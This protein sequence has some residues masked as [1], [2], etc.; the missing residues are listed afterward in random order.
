MP[1]LRIHLNRHAVRGGGC[2]VASDLRL[3]LL[4]GSGA[5]SRRRLLLGAGRPLLTVLAAVVWQFKRQP[6]QARPGA[7]EVVIVDVRKANLRRVQQGYS[8]VPTRKLHG[9]VDSH[10]GLAAC[11]KQMVA[12]KGRRQ[13]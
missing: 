6:C 11:G 12:S 1:P 3:A 10:F 4:H 9:M 13:A 5:V 8:Q 2:A 7:L